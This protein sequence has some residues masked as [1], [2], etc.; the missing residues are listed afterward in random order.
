MAKPFLT[1]GYITGA[2][3]SAAASSPAGDTSRRWWWYAALPIGCIGLGALTMTWLGGHSPG[4]AIG[5]MTG[6][7]VVCAM[8]ATRDVGV[9]S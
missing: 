3:T 8:V 2:L 1:T 4:L 7:A 9:V 6:L 5:F